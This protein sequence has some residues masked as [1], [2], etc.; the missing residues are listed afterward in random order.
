MQNGN[1]ENVQPIPDIKPDPKPNKKPEEKKERK[2]S[3]DQIIDSYS[4]DP[5][6]RELLREWLKVR[7]AKR[8]AMTDRAITLNI[9]KLAECAK[10]SGMSVNKYLEEV[11]CKG[12]AA[13]YEIKNF[14]QG[15]ASKVS[16]EID[17]GSPE[18]FYK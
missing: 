17:Y 7:K 8:A 6:T 9:K 1:G 2:N 15:P 14:K 10:Q 11:I 13:F 3:F 4:E 12:W 5:I 18:D 16:G